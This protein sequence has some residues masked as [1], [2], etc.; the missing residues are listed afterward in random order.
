MQIHD[1]CIV[2]W[3][4]VLRLDRET[5]SNYLDSSDEQC[6]SITKSNGNESVAIPS[7]ISRVGE[8]TLIESGKEYIE[9]GKK[10]FRHSA[11]STGRTQQWPRINI[12]TV[13]LG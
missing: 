11:P 12:I 4:Y 7:T 3:I 8:S 6:T 5:S 1:I 10:E 2:M 13:R 9:E